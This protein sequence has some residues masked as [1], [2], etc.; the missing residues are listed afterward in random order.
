M[1]SVPSQ[2]VETEREKKHGRVQ[3]DGPMHG[4]GKNAG[5]DDAAHDAVYAEGKGFHDEVPDDAGHG[6]AV[7]GGS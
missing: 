2:S 6:R 7:G 5:G 3:N 1:S 4:N